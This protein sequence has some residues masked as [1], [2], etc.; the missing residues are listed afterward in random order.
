MDGQDNNKP[1]EQGST[2]E[3]FLRK[4]PKTKKE[5]TVKIVKQIKKVK[6]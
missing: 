1:E 4:K 2:A 6:N 5:K 3:D